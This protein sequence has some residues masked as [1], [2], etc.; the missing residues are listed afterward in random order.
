MGADYLAL[1]LAVGGGMAMG[2]Y[3]VP[4][5]CRAIV[6]LR[7][8]PLVLQTYKSSAVLV[9][10]CFFL[11]AAFV[12]SPTKSYEF[13][14]WAFASAA[15]WIPSGLCTIKAV[16]MA[17]VGVTVAV[18]AGASAALSFLAFWLVVGGPNDHVRSYSCG[19]SCR[20][21][22]APCYLVGTL[23]GMAGL[24]WTTHGRS[25]TRAADQQ[26]H[27]PK[28]GGYIAV[29]R[30]SSSSSSSS[31]S[32]TGSSRSGGEESDDDNNGDFGGGGF[33]DGDDDESL[34]GGNSSSRPVSRRDVCCGIALAC[35]TGVFMAMQYGA[36][37]VG[38][39]YEEKRVCPPT[40]GGGG[41]GG[42]NSSSSSSGGGGGTGRGMT[43]ANVSSSSTTTASAAA[44]AAA[45][46]VAPVS[47]PCLAL[48]EAF[49][50]TGSW[51]FSFGAGAILVTLLLLAMQAGVNAVAAS[52][53]PGRG[54]GSGGFGSGKEQ[55]AAAVGGEEF[56]FESNR[57]SPRRRGQR[58]GPL[59][60]LPPFRVEDTWL[61]GSAAGLL[62]VLGNFLITAAVARGGN[63]IVVAQAVSAQ[64]VT[65]GAWGIFW[66][67]EIASWR[68]IFVWML[69][70]AL[71]LTMM[72]L[73]GEE[74]V[75]G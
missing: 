2:T 52:S 41:G 36:V 74:K 68:T 46:A 62:W 12:A 22:L 19:G 38:R 58:T 8:H 23:V 64:L 50:A 48:R 47:G 27:H 14:P 73:L 15:A 57:A 4:L 43:T 59:A 17:G 20:Y 40:S 33:F 10:G 13:T 42:D 16:P 53:A 75:Q 9:A 56:E 45:A 11:I 69:W 51:V 29:R 66:Y 70:A 25:S 5:K 26:Q 60:L 7:L 28:A 65:S 21:Y 6:D 34:N 55:T 72:V 71:T 35:F 1:C 49:N 61:P 44:A 24:V 67:K 63:S 31:S 32:S 30:T 39:M 18:A 37:T 3:P 54:G